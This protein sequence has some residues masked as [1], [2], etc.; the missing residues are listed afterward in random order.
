MRDI[1]QS[2]TIIYILSIFT[3]FLSCSKNTSPV[4]PINQEHFEFILYDGLNTS[5]ILQISTAL[6]DNYQ[7]IVNDLQVTKM[8]IITVKIWADYNHFL[9]DMENDIG[10]RYTGA[11]G[12]IFSPTELRIFYNSQVSTEY[13]AYQPHYN[14]LS[15]NYKR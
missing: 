8:P 11:T 9:D 15:S 6:E 13:E 10:I 4:E 2:K 14:F 12:Y 3:F 7:R 5:N 1:V